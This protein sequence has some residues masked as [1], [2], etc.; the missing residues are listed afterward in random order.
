MFIVGFKKQINKFFKQTSKYFL[1]FEN[2]N[3]HVFVN[4]LFYK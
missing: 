2:Y 3:I 4:D 1:F